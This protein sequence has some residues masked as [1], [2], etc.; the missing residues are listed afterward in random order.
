MI[1]IR[2]VSAALFNPCMTKVMYHE[3]VAQKGNALL[4]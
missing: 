2:F 3:I 1:P 4:S